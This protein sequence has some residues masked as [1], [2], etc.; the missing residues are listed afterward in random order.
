MKPL[1]IVVD[2]PDGVGKTSAITHLVKRL[3]EQGHEV[4]SIREPGQTIAGRVIRQR[5][6]SSD[7]PEH[8]EMELMHS[9]RL[10]TRKLVIEPALQSGKTVV[11][12]R[13]F[14]SM[15]VF[16]GLLRGHDAEKILS[17]PYIK[18]LLYPDMLFIA[19]TDWETASRRIADRSKTEALSRLDKLGKE[20]WTTV[21]NGYASLPEILRP[22]GI[23][24][25]LVDFGGS[26][27]ENVD[28]MM[29]AIQSFKEDDEKQSHDTA[30]S[31][32]TPFRRT[33]DMSLEN[34][35][36]SPVVNAVAETVDADEVVPPGIV[37]TFDGAV[38]VSSTAYR[39][40]PGDLR[41][42]QGSAFTKTITPL[43]PETPPE[44]TG[45]L[46][47]I[48]IKKLS[49]EVAAPMIAPFVSEQVKTE[50]GKRVISYGLSSFGYDIRCGRQFMIFTNVNSTVIDPKDFVDGNFVSFTGDVCIVPPNSFVLCSSLEKLNL[51]RD[52][53]GLVTGKSTYARA[54]LSCLST[55]LEAGW[56][57]NVTLEFANTTPLPI[58][59][60][61]G[62][63]C[64]QVLFFRGQ[65]ECR[66]SY[67]DRKGK[68]MNQPDRPV[69]P[70]V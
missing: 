66:V 44:A 48:S 61:A 7:V 36:V 50:S 1:Y 42:S 59:L 18:D 33:L 11:S 69:L 6:L 67:A 49:A 60:Y 62:E 56:V 13:C 52:V 25:G 19:V 32:L 70:I 29:S 16:Q 20:K 30:S 40:P 9:D 58:K 39:I 27:V 15:I 31:E 65:E 47:D 46:S 45:I 53:T 17:H 54:G 14:A 23:R 8:E 68:Y 21:R 10:L 43:Y 64:C 34:D 28:C 55:P 51:P 4:I 38:T 2:G 24:T 22:M 26:V 41:L 3:E 12:D 5:F 35:R 37:E 57:G 63:G